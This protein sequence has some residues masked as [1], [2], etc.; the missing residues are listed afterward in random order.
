M[1]VSD[2]AADPQSTLC[3]F[4]DLRLPQRGV[5]VDQWIKELQKTP[6][7]VIDVDADRSLLGTA[8]EIRMGLDLTD[9]PAH[10]GLLSFLP[11]EPCHA[12]LSAA[13]FAPATYD[14]LPD[15]GTTD[16]LLL[17][18]HRI[19]QPTQG[20]DAAQRAALV[21][22]I[23]AACIDQLAHR[24]HATP[25]A[26]LR[27]SL[28]LA[29]YGGGAG[30]LDENHPAFAG[31]HHMWNGYLRHGRQELQQLG[32]Q[33]IVALPLAPGFATAD[34]AVGRTLV[35]IKASTEPTHH[36]QVW[37]NQLLGY[38]LLDRLNIFGWEAIAVY[39]GW[40]ATIL[41]IPVANLLAAATVGPTPSLDQLRAEFHQAICPE[42][43]EA[44]TF[45]LQARYPRPAA[46][47]SPPNAQ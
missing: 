10:W 35:E 30:P 44:A 13:G 23:N 19:T 37:L 1:A 20:Q 16:P 36:L 40:H 42:L 31:L 46:A 25:A 3:K 7:T 4:L 39:L 41:T 43:D 8:L 12:L 11:P 45:Y 29:L 9:E 27:R 6:W 33:T 28:F 22:C 34:L 14:H 21:A 47:T 18:W 2:Q 32:R 5:V 24:L 17:S 26:Q 38:L 15:S